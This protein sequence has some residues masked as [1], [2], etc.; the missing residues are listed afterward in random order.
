MSVASKIKTPARWL[1]HTR[2]FG[3]LLNGYY[4]SKGIF[5]KENRQKTGRKIS[6][7]GQGRISEDGPPKCVILG[8]ASIYEAVNGNM[9]SEWEEKLGGTA[10]LRGR[11]LRYAAAYH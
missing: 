7:N 10:S 5:V 6:G 4:T 8:G 2:R 3:R 1:A 11:Y 9:G